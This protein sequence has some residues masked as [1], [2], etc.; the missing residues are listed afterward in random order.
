[1]D[2]LKTQLHRDKTDTHLIRNREGTLAGEV[3][4]DPD[5]ALWFGNRLNLDSLGYSS[6]NDAAQYTL[7]FTPPQ[8][9]TWESAT[10]NQVDAVQYEASHIFSHPGKF[11]QLL[12]CRRE[13]ESLDSLESRVMSAAK[14]YTDPDV[15]IG[16]KF[17]EIWSK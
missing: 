4:W 14:G 13:D 11:L 5:V 3:N 9:V 7:G 12:Y 10:P 17:G 1:M 6:F 2:R 16:S 8:G 15:V